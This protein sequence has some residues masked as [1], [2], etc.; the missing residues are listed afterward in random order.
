MSRYSFLDL[1]SS[2]SV[3]AA[4]AEM[5]ADQLWTPGAVDRQSERFT[6]DEVAFI[7]SRDTFYMASVS[8]TG[9]P[10]VQHRGGPP[11]FLKVLDEVT[12]AFADYRGN[13]QYISMGN[14]DANDRVA[15]ILVDYPRRARLKILAHAERLSLD[16][17]PALL[18]QVTTPG[19]RARPERIFRLRLAAFDWN[20]PQH[21]VPRFTEGEIEQA[22]EPLRERLESLE[23]ENRRLRERLA[24]QDPT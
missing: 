12:L 22:V 24:R 1:A 11:G 5:G 8:E 15:L 19:Y 17:D 13:R 4:Q 23:A 16:A 20:C 6:P 9:W 7:A 10:Y 3:K 14:L 2:A 18:A 21:I